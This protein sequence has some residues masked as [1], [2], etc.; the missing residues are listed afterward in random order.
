MMPGSTALAAF[1]SWHSPAP[2]QYHTNKVSNS[3]Q[4]TINHTCV[5]IFT[6][7]GSKNINNN[8]NFVSYIYIYEEC[9]KQTIQF[10]KLFI[11]AL[12]PCLFPIHIEPLRYSTT[13]SLLQIEEIKSQ[14]SFASV[15]TGANP[16]E[17]MILNFISGNMKFGLW[18]ANVVHSITWY[19][20]RQY[21]CSSPA[22]GNSYNPLKWCNESI[23]NIPF[24]IQICTC[25]ILLDIIFH[26][27]SIHGYQIFVIFFYNCKQLCWCN[28][29]KF[30]TMISVWKLIHEYGR[31]SSKF[32]IWMKKHWLNRPKT[33][34]QLVQRRND[35]T[36]SC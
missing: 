19:H 21:F 30:L 26:L 15:M 13:A 22:T 11:T 17:S 6:Q 29:R 23:F 14:L 33:P 10:H 4:L 34:L 12:V 16:L 31:F 5:E 9:F 8:Q 27:N 3:L 2:A 1:Y 32:D 24:D 7:K 36:R 20:R 28:M 25:K 18:G 35:K